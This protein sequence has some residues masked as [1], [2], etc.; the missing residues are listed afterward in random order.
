MRIS[1]DLDDTLICSSCVPT[2]QHVPW[3]LRWHYPERLRYGTRALMKALHRKGCQIWIYTSSGRCPYYLRSWFRSFGIPIS[4]VVNQF[5]HERVVGL[6][7]PSKYPPAFGI[8]LHIDD[9]LGVA[10]EGQQYTFDV[11]VVSPENSE[12][13][14][15]I[16][17]AV[18]TRIHANPHWKLH[19]QSLFDSCGL[20]LQIAENN[21]YG[22]IRKNREVAVIR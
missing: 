15:E 10:M 14:D 21:F 6:Y 12:W 9:S 4:G 16:L 1:F 22:E 8:N 2:E 3:W 20:L 11:L 7:G 13:A 5:H 19:S 18:D 17:N